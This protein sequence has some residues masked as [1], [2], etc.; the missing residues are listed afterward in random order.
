LACG[1]HYCRVRAL[2]DDHGKAIKAAS[3][4]TPVRIT[5]W[6]ATPDVGSIAHAEKD[7]KRARIAAEENASLQKQSKEQSASAEHGKNVQDAFAALGTQPKEKKLKLFIK[8]DVQGSIEAV[9]LCLSTI[10]SDKVHLEV[11][12]QS[13]GNICK[14]DVELAHSSNATIVGFNVAYD[15]GVSVLVKNLHVKA[16]RHNIVYE[17]VDQV[18][19]AMANLLDPEFHENYLGSAQIRQI[20]Q[21]SKCIAAGCM[22]TDGKIVR[23][24]PICIKRGKQIFFKGRIASLKRL[25]EDQFEVRAGLECGIQLQGFSDFK[26]NDEIECFEITEKRPSL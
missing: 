9:N 2:F 16:I 13:A 1:P 17:L 6:S 19:D 12:G 15:S 21:L 25:K 10:Q 22:V 24:Q 5:G 8:T 4:S 11:I 23:E 20:F 14:H 3:P 26:I 18:R 7:E